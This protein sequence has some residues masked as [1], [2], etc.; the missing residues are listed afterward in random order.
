M[1]AKTIGYGEGPSVLHIVGALEG[2]GAER[3]VRELVPRLCAR[4]IPTQVATVY[5]PRLRDD[6]LRA[7]GCSVHHRP[8]CPG[9]DP[10]HML[11]LSRLIARHAPAIVHT[12]QWSGK[13]VGRAAA[14]LARAPVVVHTEH[15]PSPMGGGERLMAALLWRRTDA[16][17]TF[18]RANADIIAAREP[19]R[20]FEIIRNGLPI[21]PRPT[22]DVRAEA[23]RR[24]GA[25]AGI[26]VFGIVASLQRRKN[27][28]L[29]LEA[30][31]RMNA[32]EGAPVRLDL[33]GDGP[34]RDELVRRAAELGVTAR[35]RFHGF[36][37]DVRELLPGVD[38]LLTVALREIAPVSIL[39]GMAACLPVIGTPHP[40]T[41][42]MVEHGATGFVVDWDA[43]A[44]TAAMRTA[45][46]DPGWR[47]RC[48]ERG[49]R[50][51][52]RDYDIETVADQHVAFY[53]SLVSA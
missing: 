4:G 42:E 14:L 10:A 44:V 51:V 34:A 20:R 24:I 11:W 1:Y 28:A 5:E 33:F 32:D 12:H 37:P 15:S 19:V 7:L 13:Y 21:P 26:V 27:H 38:V 43:G 2:G 22:A 45:R 6:E 36:L 9:F 49:R 39:E 23:R 18:T 35:V 48:G 31:A 29:A 25:D 3:W 46:D 47:V 8:K 16:V 41:L 17:I 30:L 52:E 53:R 50:R 40:G